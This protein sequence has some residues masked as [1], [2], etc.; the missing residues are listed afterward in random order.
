MTSGQHLGADAFL[1]GV[2]EALSAA[3]KRIRGSVDRSL[4]AVSSEMQLTN[5][6]TAWT[7]PYGK[8]ASARKRAG[9]DRVK[10][11][12]W[13]YYLETLMKLEEAL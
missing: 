7:T 13:E 5:V 2:S 8:S 9:L 3:V 1:L 6:C 10:S 11:T 4:V 12:R